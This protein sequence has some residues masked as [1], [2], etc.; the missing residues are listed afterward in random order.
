MATIPACERSSSGERHDV[1]AM[2]YAIDKTE[3][4]QLSIAMLLSMKLAEAIE[5]S[6]DV[7]EGIDK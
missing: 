2:E 3:R 4:L 6:L 7:D 5:R 1:D